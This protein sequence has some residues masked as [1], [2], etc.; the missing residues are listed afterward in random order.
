MRIRFHH[1]VFYE[2]SR[3]P[4]E[5]E[6]GGT[7]LHTNAKVD[8]GLPIRSFRHA[9]MDCRHPGPQDAS[10]HIHVHLGSGSPCR[11]DELYCNVCATL[12]AKS[13]HPQ[14]NFRRSVS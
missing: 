8:G 4:I 14:P 3:S 5:H 2:R 13:L 6:R 11:N 9:G 7:S 1:E 10:G 12:M